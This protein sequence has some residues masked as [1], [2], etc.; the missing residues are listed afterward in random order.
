MNLDS[1]IY[2]SLFEVN[3]DGKKVLEELCRIYYDR[4]SYV[5]GDTHDTAFNEGAKSVVQFILAKLNH[6]QQPQS[7]GE[8]NNE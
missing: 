4:Q 1:K 3:T 6:S 5:K 7:T 8:L 2:Y